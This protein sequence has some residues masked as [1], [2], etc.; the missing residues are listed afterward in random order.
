[1]EDHSEPFHRTNPTARI[2]TYA[3]IAVNA[4][5]LIWAIPNYRVSIDSGYH[6]SLAEWYA[7]HGAAWWDYIN[8]GPGGRPNL[9]GPGL[10]VAIAIL[11]TLMGGSPHAFIIANAILA[12]S[13]W[14]AAIFTVL[15]FARRLCGD[16]AAMFAVAMLAGSAFASGSFYVGIPSGWLFISIPW[17]I[18]FFLEDR[19]VVATLILSA[20][21]YTHLGGFLTAPVGVAI[22]AALERRWRQLAA[23]GI[24]TLILTSPYWIHF[25]ANFAWYRGEHGH[26]AMRLDPMLDLFAIAGAIYYFRHPSRH[27]FLIA[28]AAAPV[29]WFI[30]DPNRFVAQSTLSGAVVG[31]LFLAEMLRKIAMPRVRVAIAAAVVAIA[32]IFPLGVPNL[33]AEAS[34]DAGLRFPV[35]LDWNRAQKI[36]AV[37]ASNHLNNR[38]VWCYETSFG[39]AIAVFT[40]ITLQRGHWVEVQP[41]HDPADDLP[42]EIKVYVIP[43]GPADPF[44][45]A[46]Q[47]RGLVRVY[48]GTDDTAVITLATRDDPADARELA[49]STI[50]EISEWLAAHAVNNTMP[51]TD[52]MIGMFNPAALAAHNLKMDQQRFRAGRMQ[53][54]CL[55]YSYALEEQHPQ[56]AHG[57]RNAASA[58]G[59]MA[60]FL[61]D[62]DPVGYV[63]PDRFRRLAPDLTALVAAVRAHK[64]DLTITPAAARAVDKLFN[65]FFGD[66]A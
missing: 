31:G 62:G 33:L 16:M 20:G 15:Y 57:L 37:I 47:E 25:L 40:P 53:V 50:L 59:S 54:A 22:A 56:L 52:K 2:T 4:A 61:S 41:L 10:H 7:H 60:S 44:L 58:F 19:L 49:A 5:L 35:M 29:A 3:I 26:E 9:Q 39:P 63:P 13:Q 18:S 17:A 66:S 48:G 11:G 1:V 65:D 51:P 36:A 43:L 55:I 38:L 28:W 34:W 24:A 12:V 27:H 45:L 8:W 30:Q 14:L 64:A 32:T 21:C 23:V 42:A 46:L 6:I